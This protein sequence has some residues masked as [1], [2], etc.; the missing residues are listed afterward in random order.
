MIYTIHAKTADGA[1]GNQ[2]AKT[3]EIRTESMR[4]R[5]TKAMN[6]YYIFMVDDK[7]ITYSYVCSD[8]NNA[9]VFLHDMM[10]ELSVSG[11]ILNEKMEVVY[12]GLADERKGR[13][14]TA[15]KE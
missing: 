13:S 9:N 3:H 5:G 12:R 8:Y 11:C 4:K 1:A 2:T 6:R 14:N 15:D 7:D 10:D